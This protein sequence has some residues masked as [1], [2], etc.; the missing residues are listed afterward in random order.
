M[1]K[2]KKKSP[3][4]TRCEK[5]NDLVNEIKKKGKR[6]IAMKKNK[7]LKKRRED[8]KFT[9]FFSSRSHSPDLVRV[10]STTLPNLQNV[11]IGLDPIRKIQTKVG[12]RQFDVTR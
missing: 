10:S 2:K 9:L 5:K 1:E 11:L 7:T 3:C 12:N 6:V 4:V 8:Q